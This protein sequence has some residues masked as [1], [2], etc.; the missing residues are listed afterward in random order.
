MP[1]TRSRSRSR[2]PKRCARNTAARAVSTSWCARSSRARRCGAPTRSST[3]PGS[4][5]C[6]SCRACM[7]TDASRGTWPSR[8][9]PGTCST[10]CPPT[11]ASLRARPLTPARTY[12]ALAAGCGITPVLPVVRSLLA[13]GA[14]RVLVF[15]GNTGTARVMCLE[16]LLALKDRHLGALSLH[17]LMS[18][19]P[20]EVELYNGRLDAAHLRRFAGEPVRTAGGPGVFHLWSRGHD[21]DPERDAARARGRV[22][23]AF[24]PSTSR[25]RAP[26]A[27]R[28]RGGEGRTR[29]PARRPA[30]RRRS[31]SSWTGGG[32]A[33]R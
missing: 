14:A 8:C 4:G 31:R 11:A 29:C 33:L 1:R 23:R 22:R 13:G 30:G 24:T 26:R 6:G 16:E 17:F 3:S 18:R 2:F 27:L 25:S 10:C 5:R 21:R 32:A 20:Q 12:V 9:A 7:R 15:Y 19:E 28:R